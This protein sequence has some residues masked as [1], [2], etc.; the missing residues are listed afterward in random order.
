M[1]EWMQ[2]F[3][4]SAAMIG[5]ILGIINIWKSIDRDKIKLKVIPKHAI[6][7]GSADPSIIGSIEVINLSLFT[8][9]LSEVGLL[10]KG[11][12]ERLYF[13]NPSFAEGGKLPMRLESKASVTAY[14]TT[15]DCAGIYSR[16]K[17]AYAW[18][19]SGEKFNGNSP[20]L[21]QISKKLMK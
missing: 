19:A 3:A 21:R 17:C 1:S 15:S 14:F 7:V 10:L 13:I 9:T 5:A 12:D 8:I 6:P 20:A 11:R 4:F 2:Y 16:I 18:T